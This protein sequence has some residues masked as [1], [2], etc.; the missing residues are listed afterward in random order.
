MYQLLCCILVF[1]R[2][3]EQWLQL[4]WSTVWAC[5]HPQQW[6]FFPWSPSSSSASPSLPFVSTIA[7]EW[8]D[9]ILNQ[10]WN[11]DN[12]TLLWFTTSCF[13]WTTRI[14]NVLMTKQSVPPSWEKVLLLGGQLPWFIFVFPKSISNYSSVYKPQH[15]LD[16][17]D[18]WFLKGVACLNKDK[19]FTYQ[20]KLEVVESKRLGLQP[21]ILNQMVE[22]GFLCKSECSPDLN[23]LE[24][25]QNAAA[26]HL[27][28]S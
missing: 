4:G 7:G 17:P 8:G 28:R 23:G 26:R 2:S 10:S 12:Q 11:S 27:I 9:K 1:C 25:V 18:R 6:A 13:Q 22:M 15:W 19:A 21:Y 5:F 3:L 16:W 14:R 20:K 24:S